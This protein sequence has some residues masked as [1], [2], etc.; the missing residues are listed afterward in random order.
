MVQKLGEMG[1]LNYE[2]Y[3]GLILTAKG[4]EI[5]C[6]IQK[7]HATLARF[8][9]VLDLDTEPGHLRHHVAAGP[10]AVVR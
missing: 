4:R 7:R 9:S 5:A 3:R 6:N 2:K 1:Y 10:L 8:F